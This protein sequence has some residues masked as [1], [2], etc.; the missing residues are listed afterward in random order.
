MQDNVI[1]SQ[2]CVIFQTGIAVFTKYRN[3]YTTPAWLKRTN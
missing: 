3:T 1:A 2:T